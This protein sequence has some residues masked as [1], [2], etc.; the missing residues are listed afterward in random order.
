M[1]GAG[2]VFHFL[3]SVLGARAL[4]PGPWGVFWAA[5][6]LG[7]VLSLGTD[8]GGHLNLARSVAHSP[9]NAAR[10]FAV[11]ARFKLILAAVVV[12]AWAL[13]GGVR[14]I[15]RN[16]Q[17]LMI[18]ALL[19][20]SFV[21]WLGHYLRGFGMVVHE[22][23]LLA[24]DCLL[25]FGFGAAA[26]AAGAGPAGLAV[27]QFCAHAAA[28]AG[29]LWWTG[30]R[31]PLRFGPM[32]PGQFADFARRSVPTGIALFALLASWRLGILA[33][34]SAPG[35][36]T[37]DEIGFYAVAHR[38][39]EAGRFF[40]LAAAAALFP[41]FASRKDPVRPRQALLLLLPPS[42]VATIALG[43]PAVSAFAI[44]LL[45][46]DGFSAAAGILS[47]LMLSYPLVGF[48]AILTHWLIA[49]GR[50]R[51]NALLSLAH[52]GAHAAGLY[53]LIPARGAAGAA[54]AMVGAEAVLALA[55][56]LALLAARR[57]D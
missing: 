55:L 26:L 5:F 33:L 57:K 21:E 22:S 36:V 44:R 49:R 13:A 37:P 43:V 42:V 12:T 2:R 56:S 46:G 54:W 34:M 39:L 10:R 50:E 32:P 30:T 25:A 45:F 9:R 52:L 18:G 29:S 40:P 38:F 35:T 17:Y 28:L 8:L 48:N 15:P 14:T 51:I 19:C 24:A 3:F 1:E 53:W 27:S 47:V 4:G 41:S 23:L 20:F 7:R 6:S 31:V 11:S 16:V